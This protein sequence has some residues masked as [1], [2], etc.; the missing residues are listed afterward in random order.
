MV[1]SEFVPEGLEVSPKYNEAL[2]VPEGLE[3]SQKYNEAL[4]KYLHKKNHPREGTYEWFMKF[5]R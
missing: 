3:V 5:T 1:D 4:L 2:F